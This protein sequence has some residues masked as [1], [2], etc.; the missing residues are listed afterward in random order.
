MQCNRNMSLCSHH[1]DVVMALT[2]K[3]TSLDVYLVLDN[4]IEWRSVPA[5]LI[6]QRTLSI[7]EVVRICTSHGVT[8][9]IVDANL[10]TKVP[11]AVEWI[12]S[13]GLRVGVCGRSCNNLVVIQE[14]RGMID[15]GD[16]N[17]I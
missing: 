11:A 8:G 4:C 9:V 5:D 10:I 6:D 7:V 3:Q 16:L 1:P 15:F 17:H 2:S 12:K 13:F 14:L